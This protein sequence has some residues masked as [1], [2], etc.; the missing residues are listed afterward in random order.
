MNWFVFMS[1]ISRFSSALG[2]SLGFW[3]CI[4]HVENSCIPFTNPDSYLKITYKTQ[5]VSEH[6]L[7]TKTWK[8][9]RMPEKSPAYLGMR[10]SSG[11]IIWHSVPWD[12]QPPPH[13]W[14][15]T[16]EYRKLWHHMSSSVGTFSTFLQIY[17]YSVLFFFHTWVGW[18]IIFIV[19]HR[20]AH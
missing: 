20:D 15:W 6:T 4:T 10:F 14:I 9:P 1:S 5:L 3:G 2:M 16:D 19:G 17:L 13:T 18:K 8:K 12:C 7:R 11:P